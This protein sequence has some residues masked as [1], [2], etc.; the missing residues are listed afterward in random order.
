MSRLIRPYHDV[1]FSVS[2]YNEVMHRI[3]ATMLLVCVLYSGASPQTYTRQRIPSGT[4]LKARIPAPNRAIYGAIREGK[5]WKN[6]YLL[7]V[8]DGVEVLKKGNDNPAPAVSVENA[9][10]FLED[11]PDSAWPSGLVVAVQQQSVC[12]RY[13]DGESRIRANR[14]DLV[15]RLRRAGI[16]VSLWPSG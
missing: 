8:E 15:S 13:S 14:M 16:T 6:P 11:L 12:C 3:A 1:F 7:A 4:S 9:M 10:K 5:D 2:S